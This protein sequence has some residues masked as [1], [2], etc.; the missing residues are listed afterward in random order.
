MQPKLKKVSPEHA[1]IFDVQR[2]SVH[3]GPGI[4]TNV[5]FKGCPLR[6]RWCQNPE[7]QHCRTEILYYEEQ[8]IHCHS[9]VRICPKHAI[10]P[11]QGHLHIDPKRCDSCGLCC[12]VCCTMALTSCGRLTSQTELLDLVMRDLP[13]YQNSQG[14]VTLT[15]GEPLNQ[16]EFVC[17]F[18][19]TLHEERIHTAIET[20]GYCKAETFQRA[21]SLADLILYDVKLLSSAAHLDMT[22]RDNRLILHNLQTLAD[23]S[24]PFILRLP[25]IP[26]INDTYE[27]LYG[28]MSLAQKYR[29]LEIHILPFHQAGSSKWKAL[30]RSYPFAFHPLPTQAAIREACRILGGSGIPVSIGGGGNQ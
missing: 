15:G 27:N 26:G 13:F 16:P 28:T 14:G 25:L 10:T 20:C 11:I 23:L 30:G 4:R 21:V 8:C 6:C 9:C 29:P 12:R 2:F 1:L 19:E 7:S 5:F 18:L 17:S 22:G 3:D 24:R